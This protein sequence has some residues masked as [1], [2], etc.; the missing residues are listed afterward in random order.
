MNSKQSIS[1]PEQPEFDL[2]RAA[3][4]FAELETFRTDNIPGAST[5]IGLNN[6]PGIKAFSF[7]AFQGFKAGFRKGREIERKSVLEEVRKAF[8]AETDP[9]SWGAFARPRVEEILNRLGGESDKAK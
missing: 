3:G 5:A 2:E 1:S 4:E 7:G 8:K 6:V 9:D